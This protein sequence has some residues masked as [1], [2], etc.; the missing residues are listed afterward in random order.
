MVQ[1]DLGYNGFVLSGSFKATAGLPSKAICQTL[2]YPSQNGN[3]AIG[4]PLQ[5]Y[6]VKTSQGRYGDFQFISSSST[7]A[8]VNWLTWL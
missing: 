3:L 8:V 6:R 5:S 4:A 1:A 2:S 7:T